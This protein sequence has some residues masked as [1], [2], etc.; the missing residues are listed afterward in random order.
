MPLLRSRYMHW[1]SYARPAPTLTVGSHQWMLN[2]TLCVSISRL[3]ML[4]VQVY[5]GHSHRRRPSYRAMPVSRRGVTRCQGSRW[6][7]KRGEQGSVEVVLGEADT[8]EVDG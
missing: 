7:P 3:G 6:A 5:S 4:G 1:T 2:N 8:R